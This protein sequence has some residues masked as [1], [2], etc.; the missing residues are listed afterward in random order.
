M[1]DQRATIPVYL[2][3]ETVAKTAFIRFI[4][5]Q[6]KDRSWTI[7]ELARRA[8]LSQPEVSRIESGQRLPTIRHVKGLAE[9]F[10]GAPVPGASEPQ[11]YAD[12]VCQ[13]VD[14][15]EQ[16]RKAARVG[17]GRWARREDRVAG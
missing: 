6:R 2:K 16:A 1:I 8:G 11:R 12:W 13:L 14:L 3:G 17:P 5:Q 7:S 10:S 4:L 9:A 15:G